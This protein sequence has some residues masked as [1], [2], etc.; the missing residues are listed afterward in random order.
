MI[1][2]T[3][4]ANL[5]IRGIGS[6]EGALIALLLAADLGPNHAA[7]GFAHVVGIGFEGQAPDRK[8]LAFQLPANVITCICQ[9]SATQATAPNSM[10]TSTGTNANSTRQRRN[11][12]SSNNRIPAVAPPPTLNL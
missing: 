9:N 12:N 1:E 7:G 11:A 8:G 5:Q 3:N 10:P 6:E 2:A 4:R